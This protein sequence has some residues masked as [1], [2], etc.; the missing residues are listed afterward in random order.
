VAATAISMPRL[1]MTMEEGTVVDWPL[2]PGD[3][4]EKGSTV[5]VIESE[6]SEVEI[7]APASGVL[8][9][10][11]VEQGAT[12]PCG[13]LLGAITD[14]ADEPFD[15]DAFHRA[16]DRPERPGGASPGLQVKGAKTAARPAAPRAR[17]PIAP[18]ARAAAREHGID[19]ER[20]PGSGP[21]GRV[22]RE[23]VLAFAAAREALV[24]VAPEV[25]LEVPRS[26]EGES[27]V[28]LPGLGTDV[29]AF[30]RQTPALAPHFRVYGV[31][32]RGVGLSDADPEEV[33]R[34]ETLAADVARAVSGPLHVVGASLGA[35]V[36]LELAL[37]HP[38]R[39]RSLCLV[40]PFVT[41]S[42]RLLAVGAAW[43]RLAA[44]VGPE[45]L[46]GALLPWFFSPGFLAD[47]ERTGRTR[48]GLAATL[49]RVPAETL[50]RTT[51]GIRAWS[52]SRA[53]DLARLEAR[54]L[55]VAA[56][57]DL[58]TP[59]AAAIAREIPGASAV[60]VPDAGHAV[61]LEAPEAVNRAL[62][63]HLQAGG[64]GPTAH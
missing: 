31:N 21:G 33:T 56:G 53:G 48:R 11:Y 55:V 46:A 25:S 26:G 41:A 6:K 47:E 4:V 3:A 13:T 32:P 51:A 54:T 1:G 14:D 12:V 20:V 23:D 38:E 45:S 17:K 58:L 19:P 15:A 34:V 36:A 61:A 64:A 35:A 9:H 52:G 24:P 49:A 7:E 39:V 44:E 8:R 30:A 57:D 2:A 62:L 22:T 60:V 5:L 27:L 37:A 50:A 28:L 59:D 29:S 40:T 18:A 63:A 16:E 10:V 43:A 42:P